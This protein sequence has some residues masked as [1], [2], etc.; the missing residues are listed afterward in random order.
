MRFVRSPSRSDANVFQAPRGR[1]L[2]CGS[3]RAS[4]LPHSVEA[5]VVE[6]EERRLVC[7][8]A[9]GISGFLRARLLG[10]LLLIS[11]VVWRLTLGTWIMSSLSGSRVY[12][13][14]AR[15]SLTVY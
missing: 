15:Y 5:I 12:V 13:Y 2:L 4:L 14:S 3:I 11:L 9:R 8:C 6:G 1:A 7:R 10:Q